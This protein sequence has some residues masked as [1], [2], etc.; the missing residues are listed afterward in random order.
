MKKGRPVHSPAKRDVI[1]CSRARECPGRR[2]VNQSPAGTTLS[3]KPCLFKSS[4]RKIA[5]LVVLAL[6][7]NVSTPFSSL[8]IFVPLHWEEFSGFF[9][10]QFDPYQ[11]GSAG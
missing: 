5:F 4:S 6:I 3:S 10:S 1:S 8:T 2:K 11:L 7:G 9:R